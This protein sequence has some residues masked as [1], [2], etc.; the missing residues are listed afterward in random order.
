MV[1]RGINNFIFINL[2]LLLLAMI[3]LK[4]PLTFSTSS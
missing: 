3:Y 1:T 2:L 4:K